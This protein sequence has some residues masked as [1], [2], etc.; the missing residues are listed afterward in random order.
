MVKVSPQLAASNPEWQAI[1]EA[2]RAGEG[3]GQAA[4]EPKRRRGVPN[5]TEQRF[6]REVLEPRYG[7]KGNHIAFEPLTFHL[8]GGIRYTP[9]FLLRKH[10]GLMRFYECKG[11][12]KSKNARDS[13]TRLKVTAGLYPWWEFYAAHYERD[14]GWIVQ[15]VLP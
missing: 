2:A 11:S 1:V 15:R 7:G 4:E 10:C 9:D 12:W 13:K 5:K 14:N 6:R 3:P 8:P